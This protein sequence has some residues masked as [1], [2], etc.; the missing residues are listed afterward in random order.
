MCCRI[1][2]I[3]LILFFVVSSEY[4]CLYVESFMKE[5]LIEEDCKSFCFDERGDLK[6]EII[7]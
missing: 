6:F 7:S 2:I 4:D 3:L 5:G 1:L